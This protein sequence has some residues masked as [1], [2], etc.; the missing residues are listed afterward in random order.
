MTVIG[1]P[2]DYDEAAT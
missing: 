1:K 2:R